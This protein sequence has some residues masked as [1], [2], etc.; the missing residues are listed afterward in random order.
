M[1]L[2]H[3]PKKVVALKGMKKVH[4]RTS[5]NKAQITVLVCANAAG[6]VLPP[7]VIFEGKRLNPE[8]TKGE[9]PDTLYG[10]SDKG[11]S[12]MELFSHWMKDLFLPHIP[13]ARPVM[14]LLDGHSSHYEPDTIRLAA[15]E[16][17]VVLCLPP[18]TTH[19]SQPLDVSFFAP[20]KSY[21]SNACH[22]YVQENPGRVITKYQF[23]PLFSATWYKAIKPVNLLS[24]FKKVGICPFNVDAIKSPDPPSS[25]VTSDHP[26][27]ENLSDQESV[28]DEEVPLPE[29][30]SLPSSEMNPSSSSVLTVQNNTMFTPEQLEL[31]QSRYENGYVNM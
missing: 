23:S 28:D 22:Q 17:V 12:D 8:W 4:V 18:H 3:K 5:G 1:P 31:F 24:G 7:M 26:D 15:T 30:A 9:V 21:W 29:A 10:M 6:N 19:V 14:L 2:D 16:G 20:L 27:D 11:W 25:L 13:P